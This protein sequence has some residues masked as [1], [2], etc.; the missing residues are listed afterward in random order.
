M[1]RPNVRML[2]VAAVA[3]VSM[4]ALEVHAAPVQEDVTHYVTGES[5]YPFSPAVRAGN[6]VYLSGQIGGDASGLGKDFETQARMA[7]DN[8]M[9]AAKL[10]GMGPQ[11]LT[12]CTVMLADMKNWD[13]FNKIYRSYFQPG[14]FPARSAFGVT[15]LALGAQLEV[16]CMGYVTTPV[17]S[18]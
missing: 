9:S 16:E 15:G 13:T 6:T 5:K 12:K 10:A 8:V 1:S 14:K 4:G 17:A 7:M 11:N 2:V 3:Y 18:H